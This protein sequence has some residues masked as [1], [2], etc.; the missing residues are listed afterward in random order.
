MTDR[1]LPPGAGEVLFPRALALIDDIQK[2]G[3]L[4]DPSLG[5]LGDCGTQHQFETAAEI[6]ARSYITE[7][8]A[9]LRVTFS[10]SRW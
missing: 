3:G 7:V 4:A 8:I 9:P 2:H 1:S 6:I 10:I 5:D